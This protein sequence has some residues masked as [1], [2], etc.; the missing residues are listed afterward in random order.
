MHSS[1]AVTR[2][3]RVEVTSRYVEERSRP[4]ENEWFFAYD[5]KIT[6]EGDATVQ[7]VSRHWIITDSSGKMHEVR[8][9]GVIGI[10]PILG[11]GE[12]HEYTS[13]CPLTTSFGTMQGTFQMVTQDTQET[14]DAEIAPFALGQPH[15]IN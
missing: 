13:Y 14:F 10:Q 3:I 1:E 4:G 5:V 9:P 15:S 11:A 12:S 2:G 7:L 8:G 6:N